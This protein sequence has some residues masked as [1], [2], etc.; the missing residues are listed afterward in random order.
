MRTSPFPV[1]TQPVDEAPERVAFILLPSFSM[2]A[3]TSIVEPM[4]LANKISGKNLFEWCEHSKNGT[5]VTSSCGST[6]VVGGDLNKATTAANIIVCAGL[7][8]HKQDDLELINWLRRQ[9]RH[10]ANIGAV[11]TGTFLLAAA[12]LLEGRKCTVHWKSHDPLAERYPGLDVTYSLFEISERRFTCVGGTGGIDMMLHH[13]TVRHGTNLARQIAVRL[14]HTEVRKSE[15][16][17]E[18]PLPLR[19]GTNNQK[20][21]SALE[22]MEEHIEEQ[23]SIVSIAKRVGMT[24]RQLQRL[25]KHHLK[26]CPTKCYREIRLEKSR[27]LIL[28]TSMSVLEVGLACGFISHSHFSGV[29]RKYFGCSPSVEREQTIGN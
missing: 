20:I 15:E 29:Y 3:F 10:G 9:G 11:C 27:R 1:L 28:Q 7:Y 12:G 17:R 4:R 5:S 22:I 18:L 26:T 6:L 23:T 21:L 19:F 2:I 24:P 14:F 25:F 13:I 16:N 8:G